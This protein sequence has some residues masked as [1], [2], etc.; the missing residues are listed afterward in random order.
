MIQSQAVGDYT[1][2]GPDKR[3]RSLMNFSKRMA[4]TQA[5]QEE[6][7][8][9][10]VQLDTA[11]QKVPGR[12]LKPEEILQG[13]GQKCSYPVE[14]ADWGSELRRFKL[15]NVVACKSW[16]CIFPKQDGDVTQQFLQ[17]LQKV[18]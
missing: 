2:T 14:N 17:A 1:R 18:G 7:R 11:L 9:W 10:D 15:F 12:L 6:L 4:E 16:A 13:G 5:V 8:K 3:V